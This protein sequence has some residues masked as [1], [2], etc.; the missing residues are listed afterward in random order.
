M[1][2]PNA[3]THLV[4]YPLGYR[5]VFS[6][7]RGFKRITFQSPSQRCVFKPPT[8]VQRWT[9]ISIMLVITFL[10]FLTFHSSRKA[11]S[12]VKSTL[13]PT[14]VKSHYH[15]SFSYDERY[16]PDG[17]S[18]FNTDAGKELLGVLDTVFLLS[19]A[20][21]TIASGHIADHVNLRYFLTIGMVGSGLFQAAFSL[22]Y[23]LDI[24]NYW[25]YFVVNILQGVFQS[26][27]WPCVVAVLSNWLQS[28]EHRGLIMGIWTMNCQLGNIVGAV[29]ATEALP[30]GWGYSYLF[31][32]AVIAGFGFF[33]ALFMI[34]H[35]ADIGYDS[36]CVLR[37]IEEDSDGEEEDERG[38]DYVD[39]TD[40]MSAYTDRTPLLKSKIVIPE[41][42]LR[43]QLLRE[44]QSQDG[45]CQSIS[46][47]ISIPAVV[48]FAMCFFC[49]KLVMY[50]FLYW[51]PFF[52]SGAGK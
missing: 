15:D 19:Y 25:F 7:Y 51:L 21:C 36:L 5:I 17:W 12:I 27:G 3:T 20:L 24:H 13:S 30:Y 41:T 2:P 52:L 47:A 16:Q 49:V 9:Q 23:F 26:I 46:K 4:R 48:G 6:I 14:H 31:S 28:I 42:P 33:V 8:T 18:P 38:D 32:S 1:A 37:R 22:G 40:G 11:T 35:P 10:T 44:Q 34:P 39:C 45:F 43:R 29:I 50:S